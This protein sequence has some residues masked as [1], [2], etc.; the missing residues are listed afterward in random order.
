MQ[1]IRCASGF[2]LIAS[3][4]ALLTA[5]AQD[6][7]EDP[8][9]FEP[10]VDTSAAVFDA[11]PAV[12]TSAALEDAR[13]ASD[14]AAGEAEEA[15]EDIRRR[16]T[17]SGVMDEMDLGTTEVT[18]NQELPKVLYIVPWQKTDPGEFMGKPVNTIL[19]EVLAPV[20]RDE[21]VRQVDYYRD[22]NGEP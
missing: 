10:A 14:L 17:S 1:M 13:P 19:D 21:F 7:G 12:D 16:V 20:N 5:N 3:T 4:L 11:E 6:A 2:A 15:A 18:G 8:T 22:L 9:A